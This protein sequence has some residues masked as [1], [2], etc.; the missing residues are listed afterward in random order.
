MRV[1]SQIGLDS[2]ISD[3]P[4]EKC[5]FYLFFDEILTGYYVVH[6]DLIGGQMSKMAE[7]STEAKA[8]R[9]MDMLHEKWSDFG[10]SGLFQFP[11][12]SEVEVIE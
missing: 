1:L 6:A 2:G 5:G 11:L 12:D 3:V 8:R 10:K 7:Y 9:S 4:Y